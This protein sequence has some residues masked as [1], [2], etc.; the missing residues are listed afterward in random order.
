MSSTPA[1]SLLE[2]ASSTVLSSATTELI[3]EAAENFHS[4]SKRRNIYG[5]ELSRPGNVIFFL[6]FA[7]I[8]IFNIVMAFRSKQVWYNVCFI[9]GFLLE[10]LG[11]LG[12][13][14]GFK[15]DPGMSSYILQSFGLTIAPAF[16]M[17]GIYF[18]FAQSVTIHGSQYSVL[19]PM[20]Y[21][22]FFI[23]TDVFSMFVQ[24]GGGGLSAM[25]SRGASIGNLGN[26]IMFIGILIQ[27]VAM[28][29]FLVFWFIFLGRTFFHDRHAVPGN[30]DYKK[31]GVVNYCKLL[32]NV[33]SARSYKLVQLEQFYNPKYQGVRYRSLYSYFPFALSLAVVLVYIRCVYRV[34]E[35]RQGYSGYLMKHEIYLFVLDSLLILLTGLIFVPFHPMFVFGRDHILTSK[36]IKR[37]QKGDK[38]APVQQE[39]VSYTGADDLEKANAYAARKHQEYQ[40]RVSL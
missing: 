12:R 27:I 19:K 1:S 11:Y 18:L 4:F 32:F 16:I 6:L 31:R 26:T 15:S 36:D 17:A 30:W 13:L 5:Y 2:N 39:L 40:A 23:T 29:I 28:T 37:E 10:T 22:Y 14:L 25:A 7:C 21:S 8:T 34:V 3:L 38:Q 35:L 33:P 24:G 20:W 9:C